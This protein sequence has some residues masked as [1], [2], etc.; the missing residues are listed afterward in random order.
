MSGVRRGFDLTRRGFDS[1]RQGFRRQGFRRQ[2]AVGLVLVALAG[3][4]AEQAAPEGEPSLRGVPT[5]LRVL[6]GS[7][8]AD[9]APVLE[10]AERA[11]GV[12]VE[13]T[14]TGTL[15]GAQ[16]VAEGKADGAHDA[17]W[18]S[19]TKYLRS[20]PEARGRLG[21][22]V[23]VMSSPV[24]LGL[25]QSA[26]RE[27]GWADGNV[28]WGGIAEAAGAGRFTFAMTDP[29]ASNTGFS[30]LVAVATALDGSGRAL[31][32]GAIERVAGPVSGLF[33]GHRITAGSSDWLADAFMKRAKGEDAGGPVDGLITYEASLSSLNSGGELP[34]PLVPLYP[35]DGVVSADYPLA[36]LSG[37]DERA[38]DAHRRLADHLVRAEVQRE[39]V[40]KTGRRPAVAGLDL[41][42]GARSGLVEIPFPDSRAVVGALLDAYYDE[43]RRPSRTVYV[44][45]VSGSMEGDRMAQLKRA[46]SRLTGSDES[47]TGQYCRFRSR[48]EVVLLPFNQA[49][50]APQE[51]SVDVGAPRETLERIR[52]AVE[53]LVAGGDTAVYDSLERAYGVVGS[54]PERFTSV[55][56][57][58]DGENRVGRTFAEYREFAR[59][60]AVPVFPIVF[61]EASRAEMG[62][63][64][65]ITG[66]AVW[67][68]NSE[69][70]ERAFCQIRGYQ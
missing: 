13:F 35:S 61:G 2:V 11:T 63:I 4:T 29:A 38:R 34:E 43:L 53:G 25:R 47:L 55:V 57:M 46:L 41:P 56:L 1:T 20:L 44:L 62:E 15:D 17:V 67:D 70:L 24:V 49:P 65:E 59:G 27:L 45:D 28:T 48:E 66:G 39:I 10:E 58:T 37:A 18:F 68:A 5:T 54:S 30:A 22:E 31:D 36:V 6:A 16:K 51:F 33:T 40:A 32:T 19:S 69:S 52:G 23:Q 42:A 7:E 64:A 50:L 14:F 9:M 8:L 12:K 21:A 3:C 26:A 60:K